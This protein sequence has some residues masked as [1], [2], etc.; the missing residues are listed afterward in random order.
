MILIG[1][2]VIL[3]DAKCVLLNRRKIR[4]ESKLNSSLIQSNL[5]YI[6]IQ[7]YKQIT[8]LFSLRKIFLFSRN[9]HQAEESK[10]EAESIL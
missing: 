9:E 4:E 8:L 1:S 7:I 5:F 6:T 10:F 2:S 3:R